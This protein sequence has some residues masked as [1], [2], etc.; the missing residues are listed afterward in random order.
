MGTFLFHGK[1]WL[2]GER[3]AESIL[4]RGGRVASVGEDPRFFRPERGDE[5]IDCGGRTVIPGL[6]DACISLVSAFG[7]ERNPAKRREKE[8]FFRAALGECARRGLTTLQITDFGRTIPWKDAPLLAWLLRETEGLPRV[9]AL[10]PW[11]GETVPKRRWTEALSDACGGIFLLE[12]DGMD[13]GRLSALL[14]QGEREGKTLRVF[15]GQPETVDALLSA[16]EGRDSRL[17]RAEL[18]CAAPLSSQQ[19]T[20]IGQ[21]GL[22]VIGFP[23]QIGQGAGDRAFPCRTLGALGARVAFGGGKSCDPFGAL[24]AV[25][26]R[27]GRASP[28]GK[29]LPSGE[30]LTPA[31][32]LDAFV[33]GGAWMAYEE[34][35]RGRLTPGYSGDLLVLDRDLFT[36][37]TE[38]ICSIRPA[39]VMREGEILYRNGL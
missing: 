30:A 27:K 15:A 18:V 12:G 13:R 8:A 39:L 36:C 20:R 33:R 25:I 3:F 34:D 19:V 28:G 22:G 23:G 32:A 2:E 10:I 21:T 6:N 24:Q 17:R 35:Y 29:E 38:E 7:G 4:I 11:D 9:G 26:S 16:W 5:S 31:Q 37:P 1:I 14:R